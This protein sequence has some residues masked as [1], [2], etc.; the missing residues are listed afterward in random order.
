MVNART[1]LSRGRR[2]AVL[3][4]VL[5]LLVILGVVGLTYS[6]VVRN[7]IRAEVMTR[8]RTEA[9]WAAR[10]GVEKA[11][12]ILLASELDELVAG[13]LLLDDPETFAS[14][15]VGNARFSLVDPAT[16]R[17][18]QDESDEEN[19]E[20][21]LSEGVYGLIDEGGRVNVNRADAELLLELPAVTETMADSL[22]D[23]VDEDEFEQPDGA[24][25]AYYEAL[26][27]P[28]MP[29]NAPLTSVREL[30]RVRGWREIFDAARPDP[31]A[32]FLSA[33][34]RPVTQADPEE[35]RLLLDSL[36][37][38]SID[39]GLAPDGQKKMNV[40][41]AAAS[42]MRKR[43][44]G[45]SDKEAKAIEA[46]RKDNQFKT[47]ADLL[48]VEEVDEE[49]AKE[50]QTNPSQN[51]RSNRGNRG[52]RGG[53]GNASGQGQSPA[54][55]Q[56]QASG[57]QTKTTGKKIFSLAR[58]GEII[59]YF[60]TETP[61]GD[62]P[63]R[64]NINTASREVLLAI[65]EMSETFADAIIQQ[66]EAEGAYKNAGAIATL[67]GMDN[68]K[69][70]KIYPWIMSRSSRFRVVSRGRAG[71]SQ[72]GVVI[73]AVL[74]VDQGSVNIIHWRESTLP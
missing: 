50:A 63:G 2:G 1:S 15:D 3:I 49:A 32:R 14:Q 46:H 33:N 70:R 23:W 54:P 38:W 5:W 66:R 9:Y 68:E 22:I 43:I 74:A 41:S 61:E 31:W 53:R 57:G 20:E 10:A 27:P 62:E 4:L 13:D 60:A 42:E 58:V 71:D 11:R 21:S 39:Q 12:A 47:T 59:D 37:V 29:G 35:A 18:G 73:E 6:S 51:N 19:A 26:E 44:Q 48:E 65:P 69:F 30:V 34:D 25:E 7:Q 64:I 28:V 8:G 52:G 72:A 45:L 40:S 17:P 24:E 56:N 67:S 36:T 16:F 55:G